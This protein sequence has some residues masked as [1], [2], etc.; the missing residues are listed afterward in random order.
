MKLKRVK[1]VCLL[2][3]IL[4]LLP[5]AVSCKKD[6]GAEDDDAETTVTTKADD[7]DET[8]DGAR[9]DENGYLMDDLGERDYGGKEIRIFAWKEREDEFKVT[10][11][12]AAKDIISEQVYYRNV[13]VEER[14]GVK[15]S[16]TFVLG[17]TE[18][19][20]DYLTTA[21]PNYNVGE[22]DAFA[23]YS[24]VAS[25][26]TLNSMLYNLKKIE[27]LDFSKPWWSADI[28]EAG[29]IGDALYYCSGDISPAL[30][31]E[32][33]S[34]FYNKQMAENYL[35]E[36]LEGFGA[37]SLYDL[38]KQGKWTFD[39]ML[40]LSKDVGSFSG[41]EKTSDMTYG[42]CGDWRFY[43]A[44]YYG[45]G[46]KSL[47][48]GSDGDTM[49]S[50][51]MGSQKAH[52][53][54]E[55]LKTLLDGK[56]AYGVAGW[57]EDPV[58][59]PAWLKGNVLFFLATMEKAERTAEKE[60]SF[61][62]LPVPKYDT[63]QTRYY[64]MSGFYYTNWCIARNSDRKTETGAVMECLASEGY[65]RTAPAYYEN[66]L[67]TR[68][69][70]SAD[71]YE[72]WDYVKSSILIDAGRVYDQVFEQRTWSIFRGAVVERKSTY[73]SE[74]SNYLSTMQAQARVLNNLVKT[75][76]RE[77]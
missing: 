6:D 28:V 42:F 65:R 14:M 18:N 49:I 8:T 47:V 52:D 17:N 54:V 21:N 41:G 33:T 5:L 57:Y 4:M 2:L 70:E 50:D 45:C 22:I 51:D 66:V 25:S 24:R 40:E 3:A 12:Q 39:T 43:E 59:E 7:G 69:S 10:L 37:K 60:I 44:F 68:T 77:N 63:D 32:T 16:F 62:L 61:G 26:L 75:L 56:D 76:E 38:V 55:K 46:M 64:S 74:C 27:D 23:C 48:H 71:D 53:I 31:G 20:T 13:N 29:S 73:M 11:D 67:K 30:I 19:M 15:L 58:S 35:G 36:K 72:M 34:V 9:Y 1:I